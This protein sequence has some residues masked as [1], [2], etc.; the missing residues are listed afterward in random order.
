MSAPQE[1][2]ADVNARTDAAD[3][4]QE[5]K[6]DEK[7]V[8]LKDAASASSAAANTVLQTSDRVTP[9]QDVTALLVGSNTASSARMTDEPLAVQL[10]KAIAAYSESHSEGSAPASLAALARRQQALALME[11]RAKSARDAKTQS[12]TG[13]EGVNGAVELTQCGNATAAGNYGAEPVNGR[14]NSVPPR[15]VKQV[16][17]EITDDFSSSIYN[18]ENISY[19]EKPQ[20]ISSIKSKFTDLITNY[21]NSIVNENNRHDLLDVLCALYKNICEPEHKKKINIHYRARY[22]RFFKK[23]NTQS[24]QDM[25]KDIRDKSLI[26][27][28]DIAAE[29]SNTTNAITLLN[30]YINEPLFCEH[31]SNVAICRIG[32]TSAVGKIKDRI[33]EYESVLLK[34]E[35]QCRL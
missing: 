31:R 10:R 8:D 1:I 6:V 15:D 7:P 33:K 26:C 12:G 24:W 3:V 21:N 11:A 14:A 9:S 13:T 4:S 20:I 27:L 17:V 34:L 32:S 5:E 16:F 19:Q 2:S 29:Q 28:L 30:T 23:P 18:R 35:K 25:V 22:D